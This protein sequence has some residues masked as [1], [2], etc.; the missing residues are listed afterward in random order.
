M[1]IQIDG[2]NTL[3][4]GAELMLV[5]IL[6]ILEIKYPGAR[7]FINAD[8]TLDKN[9]IKDYDL[10]VNFKSGVRIGV[11]INRVITKLNLGKTISYF[12]E[13]YLSKDVDMILD[14][15]GF[16]Y[17]DQWKVSDSWVLY[18]EKYYK[19]AFNKN[20]KVYFLTQAFGPFNL[21]NSQKCVEILSKYCS[22][23]FAREEKSYQYLL[24]RAHNDT[25]NKIKLSCDFT[26]KTKGVVPQKFEHLKNGIAIIPN[27]KMITHSVN[28]EG[29]YLE[30]LNN[31]IKYFKNKGEKVFLLNHEAKGDFELCQKLNENFNNEF[32]IVSE[33]KAKEIKGVIGNSKLVISSRFHGVA[34]ALSQG[35]P[36]LATSWSH[37]YELLF[38]NFDQ[39]NCVLRAEL[40]LKENLDKVDYIYNNSKF[41]S[42]EIKEKKTGLLMQIDKMWNLIFDDYK[43]G[44]S[45]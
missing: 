29:E 45:N 20:V 23:I 8:N 25:H 43:N 28:K 33:L 15:S 6:E 41:V 40:D 9:M 27:R 30:L 19:N 39:K 14:A 38:K 13:N 42:N 4:K 5:S 18:K 34:S 32:D 26:F 36:C 37:K 7:V 31:L 1:N 21:V 3:N 35:V 12:T 10:K 2:V 22:L 16:K 11:F 17:S 44:S 24:E